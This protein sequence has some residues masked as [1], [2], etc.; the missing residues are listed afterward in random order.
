MKCVI[1]LKQAVV[2]Y[3]GFTFCKDHYK[4]S[5]KYPDPRDLFSYIKH[6]QKK[7]KT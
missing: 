1:C 4:E 6:A 5:K 3:D 2:T 7:K